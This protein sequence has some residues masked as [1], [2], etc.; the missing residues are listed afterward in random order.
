MDTPTISRRIVLL[1]T[2]KPCTVKF[3]LRNQNPC[4][5]KQ[6]ILTVYVQKC[7]DVHNRYIRLT[8]FG[9]GF[10]FA[11]RNRVREGKDAN[12]IRNIIAGVYE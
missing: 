5:T 9:S 11:N 10:L 3:S 6:N 4:F 7:T 1:I 12:G 2:T 8:C